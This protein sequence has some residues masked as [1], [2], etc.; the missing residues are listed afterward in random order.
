MAVTPDFVHL[1]VHSEYSLLDGLSRTH[2]LVSEAKQQGMRAIALTD[3]GVMH[4]AIEFYQA[5]REQGVNPIVGVEAYIAPR[6][7]SDKENADRSSA[8]LTL[9]AKN[10][11]GYRNLL[12][13][14]SA[15]HT[16]GFYYKP[17]I[18]HELLSE[19]AEGLIALSG[20]ASGEVPWALRQ[21]DM[22]SARQKAE[23]Y[24]DLFGRDNYF[25]E[26]QDHGIDFQ[27][28]VNRGVLELAKELDLKLVCTNDSHYTHRDDAEAQDLLLCI[29]TNSLYDD[30]KRMRMYTGEH[31]LKSPEEMARLFAE[32]PE[33]L[34]N[35][36]DVA[37]RCDLQLTFGRLDFP[38]LPFIPQDQTPDEYLAK[39]CRDNLHS[40]YESVTPSIEDRVRYELD[41]VRST[42]FAAYILFV[43]DF[44]DYARKQGIY[45][46]PRG[47]AAGSIILYLIGIT[48]IDPIRYSLTFERFLN[49][50]RIQMPDIDMDFADSRRDEVIDYVAERYGRDHVAQIVTFGRLLARAAIRDVGRALAYP[51]SEVDRIAKLIPTIP[52]GMTIDK[53]LAAS[54]DLAR[55]YREEPHITRLLDLARKVEGI[56]RHASTHAAGVVVSGEPLVHHVPLQRAKGENLLMTQYEMHA[57]ADI[58]L[59]KEDFLGLTNLTLLENAINLIEE[60]R[61]EKVDPWNLPENDPKTY[62]MLANGDTTGVFQME[63]AGMR[64]TVREF[65]PTT[66]DHLA[67][68]VALYRPGPMANI[69]AYVAAKDGRAPITFLH[70]K[71]EPILTQTYGVLVFQDQVLQIVQAIAG[72]TLGHADVLRNAMGKKIRAQMEQERGNFLQGAEENG[73]SGDVAQK[74][75]EYIEPFSGYGFNRAHAYCYANIA[76]QTAYLKST[77][78]SEYMAAMLS[79]QYDDTEKIIAA[80]GECRRLGIPLAM[81]DVNTS[82][83]GFTVDVASQTRGIRFGL[84]AIKNV[85]QG[86][87]RVVIEQRQAG[88][89]F[90][91]LDD[92]CQ[93]VDLR[94]VN[95]RTLEALA[96]AGAMDAFGPRE[97][98]L[99]SLDRAMAAGQSVQKAAGAGQGSLFGFETGLQD[100]GGLVAAAPVSDQQRLA[101][102]KEA[103]GFPL[104]NHPFESAARDLADEVTANTSQISDE[105]VG[106]KI[107]IAGVIMQVRRIVTKKGD[108]MVVAKLED[109]H[110]AIEVVVFPRTYTSNPGIWHEDAVVVV[111]GKVDV[112]RRDGDGEESHGIP[113]ILC[114]SAREWDSSPSQGV[115]GANGP[116]TGSRGWGEGDVQRDRS[117]ASSPTA[118]AEPDA[119]MPE[120]QID[121]EVDLDSIPAVI[122]SLEAPP[123]AWEQIEPDES[124][125]F[126]FAPEASQVRESR[127]PWEEDATPAL[128]EMDSA[129]LHTPPTLLAH[130]DASL[131]PPPSAGEGWGEGVS[132]Q[133]GKSETEADVTEEV[134][135]ETSDDML[136][137]IFR[138]SGEAEADAKRLRDLRQIIEQSPGDDPFAIAFEGGAS[139]YRLTGGDLRA[140]RGPELEQAAEAVLGPGSVRLEP[141]TAAEASKRS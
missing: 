56:S 27:P 117:A 16:D 107:T 12:I 70:P 134:I 48:T 37:E 6:R 92:F 61:G 116:P 67:A 17:R 101:W 25:M 90:A 45:C 50:E 65:K 43:W 81:P 33:A 44:T 10:E 123:A 62:A 77:Y 103:L 129:L 60:V 29:Q 79:T 63:G 113:E 105:M 122:D 139:R 114:S 4:G 21:D 88:G 36:L 41:V 9:L 131:P 72:F 55:I 132:S 2:E 58:G 118:A 22:A 120:V 3:H 121:S 26:L 96:K 75:W 94:T 24:R 74:I 86:A 104:S 53:S 80:S 69:P 128:T 119:D 137:F 112:R 115:W 135:L 109:L 83:V 126:D 38:R 30:P 32:V 35:T 40:K 47:S 23:F 78:P 133:P 46:S 64:R 110:G 127:P 54:E 87:A 84:G 68:I 130:T 11:A 98:V 91:S 124:T 20:C 8:H 111:N 66:L 49:P 89:L 59:L 1:H 106:E 141:V 34:T 138:E 140:Q 31:Y 82:D 15:A 85:G 42:G 51:I 71:L 73:I 52:V 108:T 95:K 5:A 19:H 93:R 13:L 39:L 14:T 100:A 7:M 136:V 102:E 97:Q 28:A 18:D 99:A 76:Y 57:V 125:S